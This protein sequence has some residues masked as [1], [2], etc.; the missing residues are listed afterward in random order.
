MILLL[1][2][3]D[4]YREKMGDHYSKSLPSYLFKV[5]SCVEE[6]QSIMQKAVLS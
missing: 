5:C 2:F 3:N 1:F 4:E 6:Y